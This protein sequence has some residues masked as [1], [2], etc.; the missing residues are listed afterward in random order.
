M[1][2][3]VIFDLD[4]TLIDATEGI[5]SSVEYV[6]KKYNL[7]NISRETLISFVGPPIQESLKRTYG[8]NDE[9]AQICA[10]TFREKYSSGDVYKSKVYDGIFD[11]LKFLRDEGYRLGVATYKREDYAKSLVEHIGLGKYIEVTC[12][13][14]NENKLTKKDILSNSM[15]ELGVIP[16]DTIFVGDSLSDGIAANEDGCE[17]IALTYGFGFKSENDA[18]ATKPIFIA[19]K[20]T[21]IMNFIKGTIKCKCK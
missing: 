15:S 7:K 12:G 13:A 14:D 3:A 8:M 4:G 19:D 21:D 20:V 16:E 11:L 17:F 2:K 5:I 18:V 9:E 10:N 6:I 1:Y